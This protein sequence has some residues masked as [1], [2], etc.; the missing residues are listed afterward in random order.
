MTRRACGPSY[1]RVRF[2]KRRN[3]KDTARKQTPRLLTAM[4]AADDF[5]LQYIAQVKLP[6]WHLG[7]CALV[8]DAAYCPS[9]LSGVETS[10]AISGAYVLAGEISKNKGDL[11]KA[12]SAYEEKLRPYVEEKH[13]LPPGVPRVASPRSKV[14]VGVLNWVVW[15]VA[16]SRV[17]SWFG[18]EVGRERKGPRLRITSFRTKERKM[19]L[20]IH[21]LGE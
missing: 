21:H 5:H 12:L 18:P 8:G 2:S 17:T 20:A 14:G 4:H 3:C 6:R 15:F 11:E 9:P 10:L 13:S 16:W 19:Q 7:R 1:A